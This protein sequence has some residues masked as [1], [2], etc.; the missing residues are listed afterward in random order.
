M[1]KLKEVTHSNNLFRRFPPG[2]GLFPADKNAHIE[3]I[4]KENARDRAPIMSTKIE[5][6]SPRLT[7][8]DIIVI[9]SV[10][11]YASQMEL[12]QRATY[13]IP[14]DEPVDILNADH[15]RSH[16]EIFPEGQ[17][18]ALDPLTDQ[19]VGTTT[20]MRTRFDLNS[21]VLKPWEDAIDYG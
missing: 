16:V 18:M 20:S 6:A 4:D 19:V 9:P 5:P 12:I 10:L 1:F 17:F 11:E 7:G 13:S 21:P 14:A 3:Y 15:F 2:F 8:S